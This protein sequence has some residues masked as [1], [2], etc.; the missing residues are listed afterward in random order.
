MHTMKKFFALVM[1]ASLVLTPAQGQL[2][3]P[4][5]LSGAAWGGLVGG[6]IGHNS[7]HRTG[8]GI[9]I[10]A[11]AGLLL[12]TLAHHSRTERAYYS[13]Y[14]PTYVHPG[15]YDPD[16]YYGGPGYYET[17][18][19][20]HAFEGAVVGG[21]AGGIIGNNNHHHGL[22]GAAIGLGAGMLLGGLADYFS[23]RHERARV[24][25]AYADYRLRSATAPEAPVTTPAALPPQT[26]AAAT[27]R[28]A[29]PMAGV[30]ALFGR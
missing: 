18:R 28:P 26:N 11:G 27:V 1:G 25:R 22:E 13:S 4:E 2:F 19:P 6:I 5:G 3:T 29:S 20:S 10:G 30:N 24:R 7:R 9:A 16:W 23:Y 12:G 17:Y 14:E 15:Y 8:E 21:I